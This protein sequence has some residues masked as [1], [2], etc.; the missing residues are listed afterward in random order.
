MAQQVVEYKEMIDFHKDFP[1][2]FFIKSHITNKK[3]AK[4]SQNDF[5]IR[6]L[7]LTINHLKSANNHEIYM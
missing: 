2:S 7:L 3:Y 6:F 4:I 1:E 5:E